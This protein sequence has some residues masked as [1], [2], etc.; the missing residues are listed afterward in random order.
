MP[1]VSAWAP[2]LQGFVMRTHYADQLSLN[3][4]NQTITVCGWVHRRRDHG[5]VIFI[6][7]RDRSGFVQ[8]VFRPE[9]TELFEL[10][11]TL[12][13]EYV[14]QVT[15]VV[16]ARPEG[17]ANQ[18]LGNGA[19]EIVASELQVLNQAEPPP[20]PL[21]DAHVGEDV[22]LKYRYIDLRRSEQ[23]KKFTLRAAMN[24]YIRTFLDEQ[25]FLEVETPYLMKPT[26]EGARDYLVPSRVHQGHCYALPQSPQLFKQII[27]MS[28]FDKYYQI[29]RCFRDEDLRLDR[30][31]EFTQLDIEASFIDETYI[32]DTMEA[33]YRGL[34]KTLLN[35]DLPQPFPRMTYAE[36]MRR[37]ASDKPD[38]RIPLELV[39]IAD[40]VKQVEFSVFAEAAQADEGRVVALRVP[41]AA[42]MSRKQLDDYA[43]FVKIYGAKGL[44]YIKINDAS[45]LPEGLQSPIVKLLD[46]ATLAAILERTQATTGD[47]LFFGASPK[48]SV[49]N[50]AMGALRI[51]LGHDRKLLTRDWAPLWV[52]D[53][54]M[55]EKNDQGQWSPLHHPFTSPKDTNPQALRD[56]PG[57]S[58]A[59]AYDMVLN[60]FELGGGSIRIHNQALQQAVFDLIGIHPALAEQKFG[61]FLEAL[62]YGCPPHGG[63][64]FGLDRVAMLMT[65]S[66]SIRDVIAF[67]KSQ[68]AMCPL[69]QAPGRVDALQLA[70]LGLELTE[71]M[72]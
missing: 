14:V 13:S 28:G 9:Q 21:D 72:P 10:A 59:R 16:N 68:T 25:G 2:S 5:G 7:V 63:I 38:L 47:L 66:D 11:K 33:L 15:G 50:D 12:R 60:G 53:F 32:F 48:A 52:V 4:I 24:R 1:R 44:A 30:Q 20:F 23:L 17:M 3:H 34:F 56:D 45:Q 40:L 65:G 31:P 67:P 8:V 39:D 19:I 64:A 61:F 71:I 62:K 22:R 42:D 36:A 35:V 37:F 55:F 6:D 49:V 58:L 26:P 51:K 41:N 54:P 70:E 29:V 27:M 18:Q 69:T 46:P 57:H 43:E